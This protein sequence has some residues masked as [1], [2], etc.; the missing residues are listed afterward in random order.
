MKYF[1]TTLKTIKF[2]IVQCQCDL[3]ETSQSNCEPLELFAISLNLM[4]GTWDQNNPKE[5]T[6]S[7]FSK[8]VP[9]ALRH[10]FVHSSFESFYC[11]ISKTTK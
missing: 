7:L 5:K 2:N 10:H 8:I 11:Q 6:I 4:S 1:R 3:D 9:E